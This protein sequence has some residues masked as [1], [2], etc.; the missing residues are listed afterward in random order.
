MDFAL[1]LDACWTIL[2]QLCV[3][4]FHHKILGMTI[5]VLAD[6][7]EAVDPRGVDLDH[8][9]REL[10]AVERSDVVRPTHLREVEA[11]AMIENAPTLVQSTATVDE[12]ADAAETVGL[13]LLDHFWQDLYVTS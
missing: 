7:T 8:G 10:S 2:K 9:H 4:S 5:I 3:Y 1:C 6:A 12:I 13:S 11:L